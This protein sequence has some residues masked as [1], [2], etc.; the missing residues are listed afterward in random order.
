MKPNIINPTVT[1]P[2]DFMLDKLI[3]NATRYIYTRSSY[4]TSYAL[5]YAALIYDNLTMFNPDRLAFFARDV[6]EGI[7]HRVCWKKNVTVEG[8]YND[9][10]RF[11]AYTLIGQYLEN[12]PDIR[13]CQ[14]DW[15][16]DCINGTVDVMSRDVWAT[17]YD[18]TPETLQDH[19]I[20]AFQILA[21]VCDRS[22]WVDVSVKCVDGKIR[23]VVA[24]P[25][26]NVE[27]IPD[28]KDRPTGEYSYHTCYKL[29]DSLKSGGWVSPEYIINVRS[30][31]EPKE[32]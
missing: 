11:D 32:Q 19:D 31:E 4:A 7:S 14:Y 27:Q 6:R 30:H 22:K 24:V 23:E 21:N 20:G 12:R 16:V 17:R 9:R 13:F 2:A 28:E 10:N 3:W 18:N 29:L 5:D 25:F 8:E 1:V 15:V 26:T